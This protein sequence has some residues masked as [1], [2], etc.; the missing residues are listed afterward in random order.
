M[1]AKIVLSV[2][3]FF[4]A[5][6]NSQYKNFFHSLKN[7]PESVS[8][9]TE[10]NTLITK[11]DKCDIYLKDRTKILDV[12]IIGL[13]DSSVKVETG[14]NF[15]YISIKDINKIRFQKSSDFWPGALIG[16][17]ISFT[18]WGFVGAAAH[19]NEGKGWAMFFGLLSIVP[20]GL[21]GGLIGAAAT[22]D[23]YIYDF[24]KG[25]PDA[26]QKRLRYIINKHTPLFRPAR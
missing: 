6:L 10:S 16:A 18:Y 1:K 17:A 11:T 20:G 2:I 5:S 26:K 9:S 23:D 24:S 19:D 22:P 13:I 21:I 4:T 14:K 7:N 25:N 8:D 12:P 3:I 15:K